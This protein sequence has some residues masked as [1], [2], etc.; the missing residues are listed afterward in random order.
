MPVLNCAKIWNLGYYPF[1]SLP[2]TPLV[3]SYVGWD[4]IRYNFAFFTIAPI[5]AGVYLSYCIGRR[6]AWIIRVVPVLLLA[7][8]ITLLVLPNSNE[9]TLAQYLEYYPETVSK[10]DEKAH[11]FGSRYGIADYWDAKVIT[12]FSKKDLRVYAA[13]RDLACYE[14]VANKHWFR[15][16]M[17]DPNTPANFSFFIP[18]HHMTLDSVTAD[19]VKMGNVISEDP[20]IIETLPFKYV[21]EH[22]MPVRL[23]E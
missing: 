6:N 10:V 9:R 2:P 8:S 22:R 4:S 7:T 23:E 12:M 5:A 17:E 14:H 16:S 20:L 11:L 19:V 3:G 18:N 15:R 21:P 1:C 13:F